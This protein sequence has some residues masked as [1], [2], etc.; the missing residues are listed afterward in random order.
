FYD[1]ALD[2]GLTITAR[3]GSAGNSAAA[4]TIFLRPSQSVATV[5][6]DLIIDNG[7]TASSFST[8]LKTMLTAFRSLTIRNQGWLNVV[9]TDVA[10]FSVEQPI[11]ATGNG[12]LALSGGVTLGTSKMVLSGG[13]SLTLGSGDVLTL[14]NTSGFDLDVQSGSTAT[15]GV[16]SL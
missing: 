6:G 8:P 1:T 16:G 2:P 4:G 11:S 12:T 7:N 14:S 10:S 5:P 15:F 13:S 3:G 9:N